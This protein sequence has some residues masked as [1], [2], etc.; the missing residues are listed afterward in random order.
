M[1]TQWVVVADRSR[2]RVFQTDGNLDQLQ[3]VQDLLNPEGRQD[4][5][6]FRHDAKGHYN[7]KSERQQG[8]TAEPHVTKEKHDEAMF[9]RE[10]SRLLDQGCDTQR[11]D[12]LVM[13]APPEFLGLL[14]QQL[15]KRVEQRI[16]QE[17]GMEL[18]NW[19]AL[20]IRSYLK[21]HLH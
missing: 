7:G 8:H 13:V 15:S 11:Y 6:D 2:A 21:Q 19:S 3:E 1:S 16:T 17:L 14:R 12:S 5:A 9:S 20:Q 10:V 4:E 18:A